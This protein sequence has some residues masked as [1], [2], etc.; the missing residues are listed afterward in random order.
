[1]LQ[2]QRSLLDLHAAHWVPE[3]LP[4]KCFLIITLQSGFVVWFQFPELV[5][6]VDTQSLMNSTLL[7]RK[8][9][10]NFG[11]AT[12][13]RKKLKIFIF[14]K[15]FCI[16]SFEKALKTGFHFLY[17]FRFPTFFFYHLKNKLI[18]TNYF[19]NFQMFLCSYK[20]IVM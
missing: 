19:S 17:I 2:P 13:G 18:T 4:G 9:C 6:F 11:Y 20:M 7:S 3:P 8:L 1:M 14:H 16:L 5:G 10:S 12:N 15:A